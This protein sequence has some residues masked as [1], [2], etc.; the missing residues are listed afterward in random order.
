M[1]VERVIRRQC[2]E[3]TLEHSSREIWQF[4][5]SNGITKVRLGE[6]EFEFLLK[7]GR[8]ET[9]RQLFTGLIQSLENPPSPSKF[10][11]FQAPSLSPRWSIRPTESRQ[12]PRYVYTPE[13]KQLADVIRSR[14]DDLMSYW[15]ATVNLHNLVRFGVETIPKRLSAGGDVEIEKATIK[16]R[17][18]TSSKGEFAYHVKSQYETDMRRTAQKRRFK[19]RNDAVRKLYPQYQ[20]PPEWKWTEQRCQWCVAKS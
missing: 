12:R 9:T 7:D 3:R 2:P 8:R 6:K 5:Q 4:L 1:K 11:G 18:W 10:A 20:F 19:D 13:E 16:R 17:P 14:K 15:G